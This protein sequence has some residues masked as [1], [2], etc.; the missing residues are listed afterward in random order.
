M[1]IRTHYDF[2]RSRMRSGDVIAFGGTGWLSGAIRLRTR[3]SFWRP[4]DLAPVSHVAVI[5]R[6]WERAGLRV[7]LSESTSLIGSGVVGVQRTYLSERIENYQGKI[8]WLP[9]H[10]SRRENMDIAA[11][12][13]YLE[14]ADGVKY[15]WLGAPMSALPVRPSECL[16]RLFCSEHVTAGLRAA[17]VI[18]RINASRVNPYQVCRFDIYENDYYQI[19]GPW[20]AIENFNTEN[21]EGFG[22]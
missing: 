21:A 17:G 14:R 8:W 5:D 6:V 1:M 4:W 7:I 12:W 9:I 10:S 11:M 3:L 20:L 18:K 2:I 15:D 16:D 19:A 22:L 13:R